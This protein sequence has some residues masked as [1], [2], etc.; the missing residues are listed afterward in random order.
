L[1]NVVRV[2]FSTAMYDVVSNTP[3]VLEKESR[4]EG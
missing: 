2:M 3:N 1:Y 4:V